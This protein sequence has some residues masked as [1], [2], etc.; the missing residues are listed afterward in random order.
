MTI[1]THEI[2]V[3]KLDSVSDLSS[4]NSQGAAATSVPVVTQK[5]GKGAKPKIS[6]GNKGGGK[7]ANKKILQ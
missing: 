7:P 5:L 6:I 4:Q 1:P 3:E 2:K